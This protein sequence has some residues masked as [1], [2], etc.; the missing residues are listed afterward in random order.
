[1]EQGSIRSRFTCIVLTTMLAGS[2]CATVPALALAQE[3]TP[4]DNTKTNKGDQGGLTA[5]QQKENSSDRDITRRIRQAIQK[6]KSLST[7]AHNVKIITQNGVVTLKG[8][9][10]SDDEKSV[11]AGKAAEVVGESNVKNQLT[12]AR[13]DNSGGQ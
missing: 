2:F 1:M 3:A 13:P 6:D 10:R 12:V 11:I 8:P 4:P 7:Y 5:E 9:V